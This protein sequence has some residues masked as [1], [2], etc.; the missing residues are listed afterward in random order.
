MW[1]M[2]VMADMCRNG[3]YGERR[4]KQLDGYGSQQWCVD[5][6]YAVA[7]GRGRGVSGLSL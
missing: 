3:R 6:S 7:C 4:I 2:T 1:A 5:T